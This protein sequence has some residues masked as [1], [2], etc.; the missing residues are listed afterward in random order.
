[1]AEGLLGGILGDEDDK[2]E[3][4]APEAL[5]GAVILQ[6]VADQTKN[7]QQLKREGYPLSLSDVKHLSPLLTRHLLQFGPFPLCC[8]TEPLPD[9]HGLEPCA[10]RRRGTCSHESSRDTLLFSKGW[11]DARGIAAIQAMW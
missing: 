6:T 5:A 1:M 9:N 4:E 3:V 8:I 2:P 7:I 11:P 10:I